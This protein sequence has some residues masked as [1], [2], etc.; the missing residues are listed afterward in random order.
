MRYLTNLF[1]FVG[2]V[3]SPLV[4]YAQDAEGEITYGNA[5]ITDEY[6][7]SLDAGAAISEYYI[8]DIS[9]LHIPSAK[10]AN[11]NF[12]YIC[13]NL[14]TYT[15]D[16][17]ANTAYLQIHLDRTSEPKDIVWW[18]DYINSLCGL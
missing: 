18:N 14:L 13:N 5:T 11:D 12:G 6:C 16:F 15:V 4:N 9:H 10:E 8:I 17:D 1:L 2:I 7:V 3:C